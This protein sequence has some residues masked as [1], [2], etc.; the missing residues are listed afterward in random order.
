[1]LL[2]QAFEVYESGQEIFHTMIILWERVKGD[3]L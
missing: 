3:P 2:L 1:M